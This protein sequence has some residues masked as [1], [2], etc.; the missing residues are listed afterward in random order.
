VAVGRHTRLGRDVKRSI[1]DHHAPTLPNS[2]V[3]S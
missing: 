2:V 1:T 3:G